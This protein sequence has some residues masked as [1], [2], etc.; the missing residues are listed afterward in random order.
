MGKIFKVVA[1]FGKI[2]TV[3]YFCVGCSQEGGSTKTSSDIQVSKVVNEIMDRF[4]AC[5]RP[6]SELSVERDKF[7][8]HWD[9]EDQVE[10]ADL[11]YIRC[12]G[13]IAKEDRG[14][15]RRVEFLV[16]L[17][18][19]NELNEEIHFVVVENHR[20][21]SRQTIAISKKVKIVESPSKLIS[22]KEID[23]AE[24]PRLEAVL[25]SD[26]SGQFKISDSPLKLKELTNVKSGMN[27]ITISYYGK[28]E[29]FRASAQSNNSSAFDF[30]QCLRA[31]KLR[32]VENLIQLRV[33]TIEVSGTYTYDLCEAK[34]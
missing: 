1:N 24:R 22:L 12:D 16:P 17:K 30:D 9:L 4:N 8:H 18:K 21:C 32:Q 26:G 13:S 34:N 28:C 31:K 29:E 23:P 33:N 6:E 2:L 27:P 10:W 3:L 15:V 5:D 14:A 11:Q 25:L 7:S 19:V 20:T